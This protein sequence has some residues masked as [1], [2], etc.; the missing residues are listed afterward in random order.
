MN[1]GSL[2]ELLQSTDCKERPSLPLF[3]DRINRY[4]LNI[5]NIA[6]TMLSIWPI[7][8]PV[9]IDEEAL[10]HY[11]QIESPFCFN[12]VLI[13]M[14]EKCVEQG[15]IDKAKEYA[16]FYRLDGLTELQQIRPITKV[17]YYASFNFDNVLRQCVYLE[18]INNGTK[19]N[20]DF[21]LLFNPKAAIPRLSL[22]DLLQPLTVENLIRKISIEKR[23]SGDS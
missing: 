13:H 6:Y 20:E 14:I 16:Q 8:N 19:I 12:V 1:K 11:A 23:P 5:E 10:G 9:S 15:N 18:E 4:G 7:C 3:V 17:R 22:H 21:Q 2:E